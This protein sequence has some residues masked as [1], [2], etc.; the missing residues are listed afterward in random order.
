M[1]T[2]TNNTSFMMVYLS[3]LVLC[4]VIFVLF[5]LFKGT[6]LAKMTNISYQFLA[7]AT[8]YFPFYP[9]SNASAER[10]SSGLVFR[11]NA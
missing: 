10:A 4:P 3:D 8:R 1:E 5:C 11:R 9:T 6:S 2:L 7:S